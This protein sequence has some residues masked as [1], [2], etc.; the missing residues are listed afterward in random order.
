M[1]ESS[2]YDPFTIPNDSPNCLF[3]D[4]L[5]REHGKDYCC[6]CDAAIALLPDDSSFYLDRE[7]LA[8]SQYSWDSYKP[9]KRQKSLPAVLFSGISIKRRHLLMRLTEMLQLRVV[10]RVC[11]N[12]KVLVCGDQKRSPAKALDAASRGAVI[13]SEM[14]Y[15]KVLSKMVDGY[16]I[17]EAI[18]YS[19]Q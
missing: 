2:A 5:P 15:L 17:D 3:C 18:K 14:E 9:T 6:I 8:Y 11:N 16:S 4:N 7:R 13:I 1:P 10:T 12:L 19:Q